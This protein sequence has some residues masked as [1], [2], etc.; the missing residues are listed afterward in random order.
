[1]TEHLPIPDYYTVQQAAKKLGVSEAR[2]HK[3]AN[4][5]G[6]ESCTIESSRLF[7]AAD[8]YKYI[9]SREHFR[10]LCRLD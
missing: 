5:Y 9:K 4:I 6:W 7:S 8:I 10:R 3:L 1:M 2:I